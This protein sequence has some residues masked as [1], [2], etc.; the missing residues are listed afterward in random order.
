M[1]I[2]LQYDVERVIAM[3]RVVTVV[4]E[5]TSRACMLMQLEALRLKFLIAKV[6]LH[7]FWGGLWGHIVKCGGQETQ[8]MHLWL[9]H[10]LKYLGS[11]GAPCHRLNFPILQFPSASIVPYSLSL[12]P[13]YSF[14]PI[15]HCSPVLCPLSFCPIIPLSPFLLSSSPLSFFIV[16]SHCVLF[17]QYL[18]IVLPL[19]YCF[20]SIVL[21][22]LSTVL[23][24]S[25][26]HYSTSI[27]TV[28][29][30]P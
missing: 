26:V 28:D 13:H 1:F 24:S 11:W 27:Y 22:F 23:L 4:R 17:L 19:S 6:T 21:L 7:D 5:I 14:V 9:N 16:L 30:S 2:R 18:S 25:T 8:W 3:A 15:L 29:S 20:S 12:C 10:Y